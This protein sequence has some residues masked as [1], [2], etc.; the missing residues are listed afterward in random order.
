M[1]CKTV[2]QRDVRRV[3]SLVTAISPCPNDIFIFGAWILG[4]LP[5]IGIGTSF[6]FSDVQELNQSAEENRYDVIKLSALHALRLRRTWRILPAGGAFSIGHGPKLVTGKGHASP[7]RIAVPGLDT[8]AFHLLR[9]A[10][11]WEFEP[12]PMRYDLIIDAV[13]EGRVDAGLLI[14]ESALIFRRYGVSLL[15]DLGQWWIEKTGGLPLPLGVIAVRRSFPEAVLEKVTRQIQASLHLA[16]ENRSSV[17]PL[18]RAM[19][20]E[21]EDRVLEAHLDAYV[22]HFSEDF[23][24]KGSK[25][26]EA[27]DALLAKNVFSERKGAADH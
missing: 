2:A 21:R 11:E 5:E 17:W 25:G 18:V 24:E 14:H 22:N 9:A 26:L 19:A 6:V 13:V 27:L 7:R 4:L 12:V 20:Q 15:M 16:R 3:K 1:F 8:T 23:G 10:A